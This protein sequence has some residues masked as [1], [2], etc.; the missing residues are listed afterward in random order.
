MVTVWTICYYKQ[1][2]Y[3]GTWEDGNWDWEVTSQEF[4][5]RAKAEEAFHKLKATDD[6]PIIRLYEQ[7]L[8]G[9]HDGYEP[10]DAV[11]EEILLDEIN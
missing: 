9:K 10:Y 7:K 6:I 11:E 8:Y 2:L 5:S 1:V 4:R 3:S